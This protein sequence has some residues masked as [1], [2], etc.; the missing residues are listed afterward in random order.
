MAWEDGP[1]L[2]ASRPDPVQ[3]STAPTVVGA[4]APAQSAPPVKTVMSASA[5]PGAAAV[6][7]ASAMGI[8]A[9]PPPATPSAPAPSETTPKKVTAARSSF[10][11]AKT[12]PTTPLA[13]PR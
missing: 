2:L 8:P 10:Y 12:T 9:N 3:V 13:P 1:R 6:K 5:A 7:P 4:N 11:A